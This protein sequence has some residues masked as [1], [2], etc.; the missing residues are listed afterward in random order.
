VVGARDHPRPPRGRGAGGRRALIRIVAVGRPRGALADAAH[1]YE[2]RL[3]RAVK[4]EIVE[5]R[6]EPLQRGT[7]DEV[8]EREGRRILPHVEGCHVVVLDRT[9]REHS[10]EEL[11]V[12]LQRLEERAPQR[13]AFVIGGACGV[14][15]DVLQA[16]GTRLSLGPLTLPHQLARVVLGEQLYRATTILRG[17]PY[18]R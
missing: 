2:A 18:H 11:A 3:A 13:T 10:S 9:G 17:E 6:D 16:A 14:S 7:P 8:R 4:L 5:V 1:D 12:L 15:P